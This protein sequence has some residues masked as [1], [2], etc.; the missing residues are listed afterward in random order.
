MF[1]GCL[2]FLFVKHPE[3]QNSMGIAEILEGN[4]EEERS[5]W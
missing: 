4:V 5:F 3:T 2:M 1:I